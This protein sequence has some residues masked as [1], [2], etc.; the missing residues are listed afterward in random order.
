MTTFQTT[1][2]SCGGNLCFTWQWN[3][4]VSWN[5]EL[6]RSGF[7]YNGECSFAGA[8]HEVPDP[9]PISFRGDR[10]ATHRRWSHVHRGCRDNGRIR[11]HGLRRGHRCPSR[12]AV[13]QHRARGG[14]ARHPAG[15]DHD[16]HHHE[17]S[18]RRDDHHPSSDNDD[19]ADHHDHHGAGH[20]DHD[21][22]GRHCRRPDLGGLGGSTDG[23]GGTEPHPG[24]SGGGGFGEPNRR[25][26]HRS[27][28]DRHQPAF[29]RAAGDPD[30]VTRPSSSTAPSTSTT[31][32]SPV[33]SAW[34][35]AAT[36]RRC[37]PA[38]S[39][40]RS[41]W[42][43]LGAVIAAGGPPRRSARPRVSAGT[44][45]RSHWCWGTLVAFVA[46][47]VVG[48]GTTALL[49][50][51]AGTSSA[52]LADP[53]VP[54]ALLVVGACVLLLPSHRVHAGLPL[55]ASCRGG[56]SCR[57]VQADEGRAAAAG[58]ALAAVTGLGAWFR[59]VGDPLFSWRAPWGACAGD[60]ARPESL[61]ITH[62]PGLVY[63]HCGHDAVPRRGKGT[64][65]EPVGVVSAAVGAGAF[66]VIHFLGPP[67]ARDMV[68]W[69]RPPHSWLPVR[70]SPGSP[71]SRWA[72][73]LGSGSG[74]RRAAR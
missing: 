1:M 40:A 42:W 31:T 36:P 3:P 9:Q 14:T 71:S 19:A 50:N 58:A 25:R 13:G 45:P 62:L 41:S 8:G 55:R 2:E 44:P 24:C 10:I 30:A 68:R 47:T 53:H 64:P 69:S 21:G 67:L 34:A 5:C 65:L 6:T 52:G 70:S 32:R 11:L 43:T 28:G 22:V 37:R 7:R 49:L 23:P 51:R 57:S 66:A 12:R 20:H 15:T 48:S 35:V 63:S 16:D 46:M 18:A 29:G 54:G 39:G 61:L 60:A 73:G 17:P 26:L 38:G 4:E 59:L 72:S 74:R 27:A 33:G 56:R